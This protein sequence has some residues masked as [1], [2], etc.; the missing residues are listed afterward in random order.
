LETLTRQRLSAARAAPPDDDDEQDAAGAP[1]DEDDERE[2]WFLQLDLYALKASTRY[3]QGVRDAWV[4]IM[5][6]KS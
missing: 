5:E 3:P 4:S 6:R 2:A 1:V